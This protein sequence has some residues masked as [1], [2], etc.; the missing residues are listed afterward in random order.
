MNKVV[1]ELHSMAKICS[2]CVE[3][4]FEISANLQTG[5]IEACGSDMVYTKITDKKAKEKVLS[6]GNMLK[7]KGVERLYCLVND[8]MEE[9]IFVS[10]SKLL[11]FELRLE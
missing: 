11:A 7:D 9:N 4:L 5:T 6:I 8:E 2:G 10:G 3:D 1:E